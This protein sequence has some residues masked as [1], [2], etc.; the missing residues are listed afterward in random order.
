MENLELK[1]R[2]DCE[3]KR[4]QSQANEE[5]TYLRIENQQLRSA[6]HQQ[7]RTPAQQQTMSDSVVSCYIVF[8]HADIIIPYTTA[9][10]DR[11]W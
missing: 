10:C 11:E 7:Y 9:K 8:M 3:L 5:I 1:H 4:Q 2:L 6:L